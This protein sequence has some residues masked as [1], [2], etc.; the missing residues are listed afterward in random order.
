MMEA[1]GPTVEGVVLNLL[2]T[3]MRNLNSNKRMDAWFQQ[4]GLARGGTNHFG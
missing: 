2:Q 4:V 1:I 3:I